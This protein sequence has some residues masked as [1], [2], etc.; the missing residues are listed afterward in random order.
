MNKQ[1]KP[2]ENTIYAAILGHCEELEAKGAYTGNGHH[3]A[4]RLA[5]MVSAGLLPRKQKAI[6]DVLSATAQTT[7]EIADKLGM[8][9]SY[10]N[11]QLKNICSNTLLVLTCEGNSR[12]KMWYRAYFE[13]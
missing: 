13:V 4:K 9:T 11:A 3:L 2:I 6:Y 10:V 1:N 7:K 8:S 12:R 5:A